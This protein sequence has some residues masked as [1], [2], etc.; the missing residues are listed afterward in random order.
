MN[1]FIP[2]LHV[3]GSE[4]GF[5][6]NDNI[7]E[8]NVLNLAVVVGVVVFFVGNNLTSLL[9]NRKETILNN[10]REANLRATEAAEKLNKAK[11]QLQ[12]AEQKAK[13]IRE[14]G[15]SK[16]N[17]EKMNCINQYELDVRHEVL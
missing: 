14:E 6:F 5:G 2:L 3:E 8:T 17:Q 7:L 9:E 15:I 4:S 13:E 16:A 10:L 12:N 1:F 11:Q